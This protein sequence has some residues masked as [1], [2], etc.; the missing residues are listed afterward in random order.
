MTTRIEVE[1]ILVLHNIDVK[2]VLETSKDKKKM[3]LV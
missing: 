3:T 1:N 2:L